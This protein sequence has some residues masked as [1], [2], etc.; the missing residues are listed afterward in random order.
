MLSWA[1][2]RK[3]LFVGGVIVFLTAVFGVYGFFAFYNAPDCSN[4]SKDGDE[5][6]VDCGGGCARVCKADVNLPIIHFARALEVKNEV[7]GAVA[8]GENRNVGAGSRRAPYVFKL[9]D[10]KNLLL[11]ERRGVAFIPPGKVFAVFEGKMLSGSRTP[12]RAT[13]EFL[14][15]PIFERMIEPILTIDTKDFE[16]SEH[17]SSLKAIITNPTRTTVEGIKVVAL[18]FGTDGNVTGAS[19]TLIASLLA[20]SSA[21]LTFTWPRELERPAR[22]EILYT[23]PW[24]N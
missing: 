16:A 22:T 9:Y 2:Q 4:N 18:L 3:F 8:Y 10:G 21:T 12:S 1:E 15:E 17:G 23:V 5:R 13:F 14:E 19:A 6:G 24:R 7:W 11:Y 20:G